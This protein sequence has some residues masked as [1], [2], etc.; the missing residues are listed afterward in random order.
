[1]SSNAKLA[2]E[3]FYSAENDYQYAILGLKE[4]H[5]YPQAAFL[6]QQVVEKI[7]KGMLVLKEIEPPMIHDLQKLLKMVIKLFPDFQI[8]EK[9]CLLLNS[10]YIESRYPPDI[11]NYTKVQ[12]LIA[13]KAAE[14]FRNFFREKVVIG[15]EEKEE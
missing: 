9:E 15:E 4:E 5:I 12:I 11:P 7:L 6:L 13:F 8:F 3:W 1:M 14:R 10:F 2:K